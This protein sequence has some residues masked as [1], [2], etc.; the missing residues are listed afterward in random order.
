MT[1][2]DSRP[3]QSAENGALILLAMPRDQKPGPFGAKAILEGWHDPDRISVVDFQLVEYLEQAEGRPM[4]VHRPALTRREILEGCVALGSV[5]IVSASPASAMLNA[6]EQRETEHRKPTPPNELGPFYK[7]N[8]PAV[9]VFRAPGDPGIPLTVSGQVFNTRGD[10]LPHAV[11]EV[12]QTDNLG[13]YDLDGYKYRGKLDLDKAAA[14]KL[15]SVM[16]GHYPARVCQHVHFAVTA[17]GHKPLITQ[18]YFST[19][20]VFEGDPD[21]NFKRDPLI[22]SR[23]LVRPVVLTGDPHDIY[24]SVRFE[25]CLEIL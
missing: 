16:P 6:F 24:A 2:S 18:L 9:S 11:L 23:E 1:F 15:D 21:R 7:K 19:D 20:P 10:G 5:A 4:P 25:L 8:A 13:H 14:Y 3:Y 17:P 12:W 22:H